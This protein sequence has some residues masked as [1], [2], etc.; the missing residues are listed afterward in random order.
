[1]NRKHFLQT[2]AM[3]SGAI[4][5]SANPLLAKSSAN[6]VKIAL[7]GTGLRGQNHLDLLLRREDVELTA[8]CDISDKMLSTAKAMIEKSGKKMPKVYTG[9]VNAWKDMVVKEKPDGVVIATPWE[10]HK[11]MIIGSLEAGVKYIGTEVILGITL[12]DHWD[13]VKAAEQ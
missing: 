1:M 12:Q 4:L 5:L 10:W 2:T 7:I 13:V 3:A 11:P 8:I 6:K 9:N